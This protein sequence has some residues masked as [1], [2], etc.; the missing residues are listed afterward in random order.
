MPDDETPL[1][2]WSDLDP[3]HTSVARSER[4]TSSAATSPGTSSR[5]GAIGRF[6]D[7]A[8]IQED[9]SEDLVNLGDPCDYYLEETYPTPEMVSEPM[10]SYYAERTGFSRDVVESVW[11]LAAEVTGMDSALW[12]QDEFG[13]WIHRFS[14]GQRSSQFG[15]EIFDPG[16]GRHSQGVYVM[17]PMQWSH[18]LAQEEASR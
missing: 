16:Q 11:E 13:C 1:L 18:Y 6:D 9:N 8:E 7:D 10:R 14:Y 12:R 15:W 4:G 17:R 3:A 2:P 5:F